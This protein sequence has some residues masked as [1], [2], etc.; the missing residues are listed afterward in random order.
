MGDAN[1]HRN[2]GGGDMNKAYMIRPGLYRIEGVRCGCGGELRVERC[3]SG[4]YLW[5]T[6][7]VACKSC[8]CNGWATLKECVEEAANYFGMAATWT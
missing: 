3:G 6:F 5:E 1:A 2:E 8:D 4:D 7:C